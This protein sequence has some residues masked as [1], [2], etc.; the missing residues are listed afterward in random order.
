[1]SIGDVG[2]WRS[3]RRVGDDVW[4]AL[5]V[6]RRHAPATWTKGELPLGQGVSCHVD[7]G[8]MIGI[9]PGWG[10]CFIR[11]TYQS[12]SS[13][14]SSHAVDQNNRRASGERRR[15]SCCCC[16][17]GGWCCCC[18]GGGGWCCCCCGASRITA[19]ECE[20]G[21]ISIDSSANLKWRAIF[22]RP[23][24]SYFVVGCDV[25]TQCS[26]SRT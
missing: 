4:Q 6:P 17:G 19:C 11:L 9:V 7:G 5:V 8:L 10:F 25:C 22:E 23:E 24:R 16:G 14:S 12:D 15:S 20:R 26:T 2:W 3:P 21:G 13:R 18:C 1:M